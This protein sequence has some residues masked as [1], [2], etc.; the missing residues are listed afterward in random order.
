MRG[1]GGDVTFT[2]SVRNDSFEPVT[3][4][5]I[6]DD[7][8][9]DLLAT[10]PGV[11][12]SCVAGVIAPGDVST[13]AFTAVVSG[14]S[15]DVHENTVTASVVDDEGSPA[16]GDGSAE[17]LITPVG[18]VE[19]VVWW[20]VDG[21]GDVDGAEPRIP[22][23]AV[24][25]L[26]ASGTEVDATVTGP[27]GGYGFEFVVP[28]TYTVEVDPSGLPHGLALSADPDATI[29]G[30]HE[31]DVAGGVAVTGVDFG[32]RGTV[33]VGDRVWEDVDEDGVYD[34]GEAPIANVKVAIR[35]AGGDGVHGTADDLTWDEW[36]DGDGR[37]ERDDLPAG[38]FEIEV[39]TATAGSGLDSTTPIV[40]T[41]SLKA[42][43]DYQDGDFGF[44]PNDD[45]LPYTGMDA[46]RMA[47]LAVALVLIGA[48]AV[49]AAH[50]A[51]RPVRI[52]WR[53]LG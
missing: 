25:L 5:G 48:A 45:A 11:S 49:V 35:W 12:S 10:G 31:V 23:V 52:D 34:A 47:I 24:R 14:V 37:Y 27:M 2:V 16:S 1:P 32:A 40:V 19:G 38:L 43:D 6:V 4:T 51:G 53:R 30:R 46:D 44:A 3:I 39:D 42:G 29:D 9:G 15:G 21:N 7:V 28:G 36:T 18:S 26:D 22:D 8:F 50:R 33:T 41:V 13:C 20:D 17:V